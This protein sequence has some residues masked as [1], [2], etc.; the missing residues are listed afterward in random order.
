MEMEWSLLSYKIRERNIG[1][2]KLVLRNHMKESQ[3]FQIS[4]NKKMKKKRS[5]ILKCW[6]VGIGNWY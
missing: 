2:D 6:A 3:H 5:S 1:I 4:Y